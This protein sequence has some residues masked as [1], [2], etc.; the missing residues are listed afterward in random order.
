MGSAAEAEIGASY[1]NGQ[2]CVAIRKTL[3]KLGHSQPPL[4]SR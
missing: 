3:I 4:L 2:D 1:M